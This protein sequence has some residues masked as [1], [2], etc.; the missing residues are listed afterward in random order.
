[1][2]PSNGSQ[3]PYSLLV[4][5]A[6]GEQLRDAIQQL[7]IESREIIMLREYGE[8]SYQEIADVLEVPIGT[9]MSRLGRARSKLR[10]LLL[11]SFETPTPSAGKG[12]D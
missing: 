2:I 4:G 8:L 3:D 7:P 12:I 1:V 5:K 11:A 10:T 9:V 6:E